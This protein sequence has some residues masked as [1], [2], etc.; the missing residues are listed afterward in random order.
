MGKFVNSLKPDLF[1][2]FNQFVGGVKVPQAVYHLNLTRFMPIDSNQGIVHRL[3]EWSRNRGAKLAL[4]QADANLF[5]SNYL[6]ECASKVHTPQNGIAKVIYIGLPDDLIDASSKLK[7]SDA[8]STSLIAI[9]NHSEHKDN[10]TLIRVLHSLVENYPAVNWRLKIAA[11]IISE[12][13]KPIKKLA[14]ELGVDD[15]IEWLGFVDQKELTEHLQDSLCLVSTSRI[16]SFCTVALESMARGCPAVVAD[17]SSMSE[18][19][20]DAAVLVA[21][22]DHHGFADAIATFQAEPEVRA[23]FVQFGFERIEEFRGDRCGAEFADLMLQL[24]SRG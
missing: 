15:K 9:T 6:H 17:T 22:G 7:S 16:E 13:W 8:R 1:F 20:G 12:K 3:V 4:Q 14:V 5:E 21:A 24:T 11:K 19:V 2:S 18:S 10:A 23:D